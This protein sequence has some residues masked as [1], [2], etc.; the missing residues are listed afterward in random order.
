YPVRPAEVPYDNVPHVGARIKQK[1][2]K[3]EIELALNTR[4]KNYYEPRGEQIAIDVNGRDSAEGEWYYESG[5]MDKQLLVSSRASVG[6][7]RYAMG[8]LREGEL[9]ITPLLGVLQLRPNFDYMNKGEANVIQA[10]TNQDEDSQDEEEEAKALTLRFARRESDRAKAQRL[11]SFKYLEKQ[12]AEEEWSNL[13]YHPPQHSLAS[14]DRLKLFC[15]DCENE[16]PEMSLSSKAYLKYLMPSSKKQESA[17]PKMPQN[18]LSMTQLREMDLPDQVKALLRN[19]KVMSFSQLCALL[20]PIGKDAGILKCVQQFGVLVQGCWVVKSEVLYPDGTVSPNSGI[21]SEILCRGRDYIMW[22]FTQSRVVVRKDIAT[23]TKLPNDD[24]KDI[25]EQMARMRV[26]QGWEFVLPHD[27]EFI[28]K[29]PDV[30]K[31]QSTFWENKHQ[32]FS[33]QLNLNKIHEKGV[34]S[35]HKRS[36]ACEPGDVLCSG[37]S[38]ALLE[39]VI[40]STGA[41]EIKIKWPAMHFQND[42]QS[43][44]FFAFKTVGD[45][46]LDKLREVLLGMFESNHSIRKTEFQNKATELIGVESSKKDWAVL[47]Q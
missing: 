10:S 43:R 6:A 39:D 31:Q 8:I 13:N 34:T 15:E 24:I 1:Q 44:R 40:L 37:I 30:V 46:S 25:L 27:V 28:H 2:Q 35:D 3:V 41:Q 22:R 33:S 9:H 26:A 36:S 47:Q 12:E 4:S 38:D 5:K 19:A 29:H 14:T 7:S 18:V 21:P 42:I 23:V 11:S 32:M 20:S 45:S 16:A 17:Q